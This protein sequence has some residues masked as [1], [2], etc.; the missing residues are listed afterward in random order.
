MRLTKKETYFLRGE[1]KFLNRIELTQILKKLEEIKFLKNILL[2]KDQKKLFRLL[3]KPLI[4]LESHAKVEKSLEVN[5]TLKYYEIMKVKNKP[6][7]F[8]ERIISY[9]NPKSSLQ[10]I[11]KKVDRKIAPRQRNK[12]GEL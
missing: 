3:K 9:L 2:T 1:N 12:D 8:D 5:N 4:K 6:S 7:A 10:P 11:L